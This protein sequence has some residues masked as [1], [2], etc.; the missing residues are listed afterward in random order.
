VREAVIPE[1]E[2]AGFEVVVADN[3]DEASSILRKMRRIDLLL[4]DIGMPGRINGW[5][6]AEMARGRHP[7]LPVIYASG[8]APQQGSEIEGSL[9]LPK[10]YRI[11]EILNAIEELK[12]HEHEHLVQDLP[13]AKRQRCTARGTAGVVKNVDPLVYVVTPENESLYQIQLN[14]AYRLR[15]QIFLEQQGWRALADPKGRELDEFDNKNAV[16]MLCIDQGEVL[17]YQRL[18]PTTRPHLLSDIV[19]ELCV[20]ERPVGAHIWE[21]SHHCI[22]PVDRAGRNSAG[23]I[24]NTLGLALVEWGL[25]CG[26]TRFVIEIEPTGIIPLVQLGF[27]PMPLGPP[28]K[29]RGRD[30]IGVLVAFDKQTLDRFRKMRGNEKKV[31][32]GT[33]H[34]PPAL[35]HA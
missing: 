9:F 31:L 18:L 22:A 8:F 33:S 20:G 24:A 29:I 5:D 2:E 19:P 23:S 3:G 34:R 6:L 13:S 27:Q 28:C 35:L 4:T 7:H 15:H 30:L 32:A 25:E 21:L 16:H 10:P 26:V 14:Q 11:G 1:L 17:G 12:S